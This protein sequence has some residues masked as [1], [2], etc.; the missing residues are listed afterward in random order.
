MIVLRPWRAARGWLVLIGG[1]T[2]WPPTEPIDREAIARMDK[3]KPL[4]FLPA[5]ACPP[6]YAQSFL[7]TYTRLGAPDG[8]EVPVRD[9]AAAR[10]PKN[11]ELLERAGLIYI[12]GGETRDL[13]ATMTGTPALDA[14]ASAYEN[15]AVIVGT[16]AGAIGLATFGVSIDPQIGVLEG[17]GWVLRTLVSV[18][19]TPEREES[20]ARALRDHSGTI[21][22][23]LPENTAIAIGPQGENEQWGAP[24]VAITPGPKYAE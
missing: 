23:A 12:G 20:F 5:A 13:L 11:A 14:M 17:W 3:R 22:I 21:G 9:S 10:D 16:S 18:H 7:E 24:G 15:G 2:S 8:Y 6:G 4:A 1:S 19:H